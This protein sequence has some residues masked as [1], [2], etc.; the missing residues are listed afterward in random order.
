M[1]I[2][3]KI[4][5][6]DLVAYEMFRSGRSVYACKLRRKPLVNSLMISGIFAILFILI[7]HN[8]YGFV[9]YLF[10]SGIITFWHFHHIRTVDLGE[11]R[12]IYTSKENKG[13]I[14]DHEIELEP[15]GIRYIN[16]EN[17][18]IGKFAKI[19]HIELT[20]THIFIFTRPNNVYIIPK[21]KI[22]EGD[23]DVITTMIQEKAC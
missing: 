15:D 20:A 21:S 16:H 8:L 14:G 4:E 5:L 6:E 13:L 19:E 23:L 2:I 11:I 22:I 7:K 17:T 18:R 9:I 12:Q 3:Y 1:K 10:V